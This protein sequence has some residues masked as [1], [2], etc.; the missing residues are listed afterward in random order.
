MSVIN[1]HSLQKTGATFQFALEPAPEII[2]QQITQ[3]PQGVDFID[4]AAL[5]S[6][7]K[8]E[9]RKNQNSLFV[10]ISPVQSVRLYEP[11]K[12]KAE[13]CIDRTNLYGLST[14]SG[15]YL[16]DLCT[17]DGITI[18]IK[19]LLEA[20]QT[21]HTTNAGTHL[22]SH[23]LT[24][25]NG[26]TR[27]M[28]IMNSEKLVDSR[29]HL[30]SDQA[31]DPSMIHKS[32]VDLSSSVPLEQPKS[33]SQATSAVS[34]SDSFLS[35]EKKITNEISSLTPEDNFQ[36]STSI[37]MLQQQAPSPSENSKTQLPAVEQE[38]TVPLEREQLEKI[39]DDLLERLTQAHQLVDSLIEQQDRVA[40]AQ[41]TLQHSIQTV[42]SML[43]NSTM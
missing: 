39:V 16:M 35:F 43:G 15:E 7:C 17:V 36:E 12:R 23:Q 14:S 25:K 5:S 28:K 19:L 9:M 2:F 18:H 8:I 37:S 41:N 34:A 38:A 13:I 29:E 27:Q 11:N 26:V 3:L 6:V 42:A 1:I 33:I 21:N 40:H 10:S 20:S 31:R 4:I 30:V 22:Q 24:S 32:T